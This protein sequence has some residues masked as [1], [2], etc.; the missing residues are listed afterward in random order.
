MFMPHAKPNFPV[1]SGVNSTV[2]LAMAGSA[3]LTIENDPQRHAL[4]NTDQVRRI[5]ALDQDLNLLHLADKLSLSRLLGAEK[6][7]R[8]ETNQHDPGSDYRHVREIHRLSMRLEAPRT[9]PSSNRGNRP[10]SVLVCACR[11]NRCRRPSAA[12]RP[13]QRHPQLIDLTLELRDAWIAHRRRGLAVILA[14]HHPH[15]HAH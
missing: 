8:Q 12:L 4:A 11:W 7:P 14:H 2:V 9:L 13:V 15:H 10:G 5:A 3:L 6:E 1:L